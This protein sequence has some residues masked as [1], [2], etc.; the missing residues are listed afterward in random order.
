MGQGRGRQTVPRQ[1]Q[2]EPEGGCRKSKSAFLFPR[3][4]GLLHLRALKMLE[5]ALTRRQYLIG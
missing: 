4:A 1:R 3:M 2:W 5:I